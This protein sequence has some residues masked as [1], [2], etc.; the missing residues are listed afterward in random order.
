MSV[1]LA[2]AFSVACW[3]AALA[4]AFVEA[5]PP[6]SYNLDL[7]PHAFALFAARHLDG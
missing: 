4:G 6:T 7:Y 2:D 3:N 5:H 1:R